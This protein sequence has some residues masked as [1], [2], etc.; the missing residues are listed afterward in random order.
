MS[1]ED[2]SRIKMVYWRTLVILQTLTTLLLEYSL[3]LSDT[4]SLTQ[5]STQPAGALEYHKIAIG[6][7]KR[8]PVPTFLWQYT[9]R[10]EYTEGA[11]E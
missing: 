4:F 7:Q 6:L 8:L 11:G 2:V 10:G 1:E 3:P 5:R 9:T